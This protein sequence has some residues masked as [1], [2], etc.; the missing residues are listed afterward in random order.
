MA[1][2]Q[3]DIAGGNGDLVATS[4]QS[5]NF[6]SGSTGWQ[7]ARD[8]SAEFNDLIIR[9][10]F[11][12]TDFVIN[13]SGAFFYSGT[14][15]LGNLIASIAS[16][17]GTD[18]KGNAYGAGVTSYDPSGSSYSYYIQLYNNVLNFHYNSL[19]LFRSPGEIQANEPLDSTKSPSLELIS[20]DDS[21]VSVA[22][23]PVQALVKVQGLSHDG[24]SSKPA[25]V[26]EGVDYLGAATTADFVLK[27]TV[28]QADANGMYFYSGTP[29]NG[30][31]PIAY[32]AL[33][34][35]DP[36]GNTLSTGTITSLFEGVSTLLGRGQLAVKWDANAGGIS[37]APASTQDA[38]LEAV[39]PS[40]NNIAPLLEIQGPSA[41][42]SGIIIPTIQLSGQSEDGSQ[43]PAIY[44][45]NSDGTTA[46][47]LYV[48]GSIQA[49]PGGT[50][51]TWHTMPAFNTH[52]SHG[53]PVPAYRLMPDNTV[54]LAG[55]VSVT[56]GT[57]SG[58]VVTLPSST[59]FP[60]DAQTF[61][62]AY[63]GTTTNSCRIGISST[64][65]INLAGG[66]TSGAWTFQ[67]D[68]IRFSLDF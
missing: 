57:S 22:G 51:E 67:L 61:P 18:A 24:S 28:I 27:G 14:P 9:G 55:Q 12:G 48:L 15:A 42:P 58:T 1:G 20:P 35:T 19:S 8:G 50:P 40:A 6:L 21:T 10:T 30:N 60:A 26:I 37:G 62:V 3:H 49:A 5:P 39:I 63:T 53:S 44:F 64:G 7:V 41:K 65:A 52:F 38:G 46:L 47:P 32:I 23:T 4:V 68:G 45:I 36:F 59:Y 13:A 25:V 2:F 31:P 54:M 56:S 43:T 17:G 29:A 66:P 16:V 34:T 11:D 33:S